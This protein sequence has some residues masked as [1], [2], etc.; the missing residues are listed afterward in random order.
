MAQWLD[1]HRMLKKKKTKQKLQNMQ[2]TISVEL[3]KLRENHL[4]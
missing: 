1:D 3:K 2:D 4:K